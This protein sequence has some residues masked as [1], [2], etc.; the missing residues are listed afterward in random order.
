MQVVHSGDQ[1][2]VGAPVGHGLAALGSELECLGRLYSERECKQRRR[3]GGRTAGGRRI[4]NQ[5]NQV[6]RGG[7]WVGI[8]ACREEPVLQGLPP[9]SEFT[10]EPGLAPS[11]HSGVGRAFSVLIMASLLV[12]NTDVPST[13]EVSLRFH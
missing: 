11:G 7:P 4:G 8:T 12:G 6:R 3:W 5:Q 1:R 10:P 13:A 9:I 2:P